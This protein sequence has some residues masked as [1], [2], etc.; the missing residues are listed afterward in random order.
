MPLR[1]GTL[2]LDRYRIESELA[3]GG[4]G[5]VYLAYDENMASHCA[6]KENLTASRAAERQFRREAKLLASLSHPHLPRVTNHFILEGNQYLVMDYV[7]GDD[8]AARLEQEGPLRESQALR[9][10]RQIGGALEYLHSLDPPVI[11][12]DIKPANIKINSENEAMLVDF[13]IAKEAAVGRETS[14]GAKGITPGFAPPE[15]YDMGQTDARTDIYAFGATLY[16]LLS[17]HIPPDSVERLIGGAQMPPLSQLR[18]DLAG[19]VGPVVARA[20]QV[21][22]EDRFQS[23]SELSAALA[24]PEYGH[25]PS[26]PDEMEAPTRRPLRRFAWPAVGVGISLGTLALF[27]LIMLES[28]TQSGLLEAL[29]IRVPRFGG[30]AALPTIDL[31]TRPPGT[32]TPSPTP[33]TIP[34]PT[35]TPA[36]VEIGSSNAHGWRLFDSWQQGDGSVPFSMSQDGSRLAM[37]SR[38]GVDI[39]DVLTGSLEEELQGFIIGRPVFALEYLEDS[40][41]VLFDDEIL[42]YSLETKNLI[43]QLNFPGREM[44]VSPDQSRLAV[45]DE[46]VSLLDLESDQLLATLGSDGVLHDFVFSP[47]GRYFALT[48][49]EDVDLY[50][51][52]SGQLER[53]LRGHGEP[54]SGLSFTMDSERLVAA[55]GDVWEVSSGDLRTI[56]DSATD[57]AV[58]SPNAELIVGEDGSAWDL[59]TGERLTIVPFGNERAKKLEFTNDGRFLVRQDR[60]GNIQLWTADPNAVVPTPPS[61]M[62]AASLPIGEE[63]TPLNVSE[64]FDIGRI[65]GG[66]SRILISPDWTTAAT[67]TSAGS[68][69]SLINLQDGVPMGEMRVT[70][71]IRD[72]AYLGPDFLTIIDARGTERW[73][74]WTQ[75]LMQEYDFQGSRVMASPGGEHFA[76]QDKYISVMDPVSGA[77]IHNLGSADSGQD[78]RFAP[79]GNHLAI[80]AGPAVGLWDMQTGRRVRQFSGHGPA[81][82]DLVFTPDGSLLLSASGD[83][84]EVETGTRIATFDT[85]ASQLAVSPDGSLVAGTDGSLWDGQTGQYLGTLA[86]TAERVWFTPNER[87]IVFARRSG[88]VL[89]YGIAP[90]VD[91]HSVGAPPLSEV[92]LRPLTAENVREL[93]V[94]GW[95]GD[96]PLFEV[97]LA[98]DQGVEPFGSEPF[99]DIDLGPSKDSISV[100]TDQG[101]QAI[102]P[103]DGQVLASYEFFLNPESIREIAYLGETLLLLKDEAGVEQWDL[104]RSRMMARYDVQGEGLVASSDG[105]RFA[106]HVGSGVAVIDGA[107]G[108]VVLNLPVSQAYAFSPDG[109]ALAL[110]RGPVVELWDLEESRRT[111][112]LAGSGGRLAYSADGKYLISGEGVI[113]DVE[114]ASRI[115]FFDAASTTIATH[116]DLFASSDGSLRD[117][118]SGER[119][120][121]LFDLRAPAQEMLFAGDTLV[122]RT[123][124]GN[125]YV[126]GVE[127]APASDPKPTTAGAITAADVSQL[128]ML[129]HIGRGRLEQAVWSPDARYLAVNSS[130]NTLIYEAFELRLVDAYIGAKTLA[131]DQDANV[132]IGGAMPLQLIDPESGSIIADFGPKGITAAAFNPDESSL[133]IGGKI[134]E[135]GA[136]DGLAIIDMEDGLLREIEGGRG[137]YAEVVSLEFTPDGTYLAQSLPGAIQLWEVE[138]GRLLRQPI[139]GNTGPA[140]ISPDGRHLAYFTSRFIIE[141]LTAG[142]QYRSINA[143][144]TPFFPTGLDH[145]SLRPLDYSFGSEGQLKVFYRSLNRRTF[146]EDVA[147]IAWDIHASPVAAQTELEQLIRLSDL[148][149]LFAS[150]YIEQ[151][152]QLIPSF[153][154]SGNQQL[155]ASLTPD[156]VVRVWRA[157]DGQFLAKSDPDALER[158]TQSP[159]GD[160]L[161]VPNALGEVQIIDLETGVTELILERTGFPEWLEYSSETL[162]LLLQPEDSLTAIDTALGLPVEAYD[163]GGYSSPEYLSLGPEGHLLANLQLFGGQNRLQLHSLSPHG[164]LFELDRYPIPAAPRISPSGDMLA[165]PRRGE[166][167]LWDLHT[168]SLLAALESSAG[169]LGALD[170]SPDG[171][172]L[173]ASNGQI[174]DLDGGELIATFDGLDPS[175]RVITNGSVILGEDGTIWSLSDGTQLG[176]LESQPAVEFAFTPDGSKILWLPAGGVI[177][178]WGVESS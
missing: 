94:L 21:N 102:R 66:Q 144:G 125:I 26:A 28:W 91:S 154:I 139:R 166:V 145:P 99:K 122:W 54:T 167:E 50:R 48:N 176:Q 53:T 171:S 126:W 118:P 2:L 19:N 135:S 174:W 29:D 175:M 14:T 117:L 80:A 140:V 35:A 103:E 107:S 47:D 68:T 59:E 55:S 73:E 63:I 173:V 77:R 172:R 177:E 89:I 81:T 101:V 3:R 93:E 157:T 138:S 104:E 22:T 30:F 23:I 56:F 7:E 119:V 160:R 168:N 40:L 57:Y 178:I 142:G 141:D 156:G 39:F 70:G 6:V 98:R 34:S 10:A 84:W 133:A 92:N 116:V 137:T 132:L 11:H 13:G 123:E 130:Q 76:V 17:G 69:I 155:L 151:R 162:L 129:S 20:M 61:G 37:I 49:G 87:Q 71:G 43:G 120:A 146:D 15:Q 143:D 62:A 45:R 86:Q 95:W 152:P 134:R 127:A 38:Q 164:P 100:L 159:N 148:L 58:V 33:T 27:V 90:R 161:A 52:D 51:A 41:L 46:Y 111:A 150:D 147:L 8:L 163:L 32:Q 97:R 42:H 112:T 74:V 44:L 5:A 72:A 158:M 170:F 85:S 114:D 25:E 169:T 109:S 75:Q 4:F 115:G 128:S 67:W 121:T 124:E 136:T 96:D 165:I 1:P 16:N 12:R 79:D 113:W 88:E 149:G 108:E 65:S 18:P 64:L 78:F 131:F 60:E 24:D 153:E 36:P 105:K 9:W 31:S 83:L 110:S 82:H 106:L